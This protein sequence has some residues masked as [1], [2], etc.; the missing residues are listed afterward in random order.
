MECHP[1]DLLLPTVP[2]PER[3]G[4]GEGAVVEVITQGE[5]GLVTL[6]LTYFRKHNGKGGMHLVPSELDAAIILQVPV[7]AR[8]DV[9][10][11]VAAHDNLAALLVEFEEIHIGLLLLDNELLRCTLVDA[12]EQGLH[13]VGCYQSGG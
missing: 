10:P 3:H 8:C 6:L 5:V 11:S 2:I 13:R 9:D 12:F 1:V 7:D 4:V